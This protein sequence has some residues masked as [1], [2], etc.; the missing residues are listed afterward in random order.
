MSDSEETPP[1]YLDGLRTILD[2]NVWRYLT[3]MNSEGD[4]E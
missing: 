2:E 3:F 1:L 4:E